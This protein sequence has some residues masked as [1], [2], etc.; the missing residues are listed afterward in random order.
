MEGKVTWRQG[1][2]FTGEAASG[3][4]IPIGTSRDHGGHD[5]GAAP[6]ELMAMGLA[7]CSGMDVIS[8]LK[9]KQQAVTDFEVKFQIER[10]KDH[11]KVFTHIVLEYVVTGHSVDPAAVE[12]AVELSTTKYCP[13]Y[14][15]M[16]QVVPIEVK[17]SV[18]EA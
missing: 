6:M 3:W 4:R 11:P 7:S 18:L 16:K 13:G 15:M 5:D 1:M 17:I 8:I 10:A 12:R 2:S 14:A 9:K